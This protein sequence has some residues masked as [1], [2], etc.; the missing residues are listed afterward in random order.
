MDTSETVENIMGKIQVKE[1]TIRDQQRLTFSGK[2]LE[3]ERMISDCK[4]AHG[5]TLYAGGDFTGGAA[6]TTK[7]ITNAANMMSS[8]LQHLQTALAAEQVTTA[9]LRRSMTRGEAR[10][11][12]CRRRSTPTWNCLAT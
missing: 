3:D 4:V 1:G 2:Q 11:Y 9:D 7:E 12:K 10:C 5:C 6:I 8:Q